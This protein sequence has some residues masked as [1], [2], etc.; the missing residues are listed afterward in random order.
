M[1]IS[2]ELDSL[3]AGSSIGRRT[4]VEGYSRNDA[5]ALCAEFERRG[6][7]KEIED[8]VWRL[9]KEQRSKKL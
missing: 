1:D 3:I 9:L 2:K 6:F 7:D 5:A 4:R 8:A